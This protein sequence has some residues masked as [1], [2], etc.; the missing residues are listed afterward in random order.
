M[1]S[2]TQYTPSIWV[3]TLSAYIQALA[4]FISIL[5]KIQGAIKKV[6]V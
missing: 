6:D 2:K 4:S 3:H 1:T 5:V